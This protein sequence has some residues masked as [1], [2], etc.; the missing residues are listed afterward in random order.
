[1][2]IERL[3]LRNFKCYGETEFELS[4]GVT[5]I[6]GLNG[7]GKSSLLEACFF[8]LYGTKALETTL[9]EV[10]T[11]GEDEMT[12]ELWFTHSGESYHVHREVRVRDGSAH[13]AKCVLEGSDG[14]TE[15]A[16]DVRRRVTALLRM[17]VDAFINCAYVRQGE[18]NKLI[19]AKPSD[20]QD[21]LDEL[22]QLGKLEEYR[23]RASDARV[24]VGRVRDDKQ[25]ALGELD[26]QIAR[27]EEKGLH[28]RRSEVKSKLSRVTKETEK[29]E[30][31]RR[32]AEKTVEQA[33]S[34]LSEY[35]QKREQLDSLAENIETVR[36]RIQTTAR[37]REQLA[38]KIETATERVERAEDKRDKLLETLDISA[39]EPVSERVA[40]ALSE[41]REEITQ[42]TEQ[43]KEKSVEKQQHDSTHERV[44]ERA[45]ELESKAKEKRSEADRLESEVETRR[46]ELSEKRE[47]LD[48]LATEIADR[49]ELFAD[50]PVEIGAA[51]A[52]SEQ[53]SEELAE[54]R[55]RRAEKAAALE[56]ARKRLE[57][58]EQLREAGSCPECGQPV[59][60]S[61]HVDALGDRR[62]R[63]STL[64]AEVEQLRT[65]VSEQEATVSEAE[66][67]VEAE[68]EIEQRK[69]ERETL[70]QLLT[71]HEQTVEEKTERAA[72]LR[73]EATLDEEKATAAREEATDAETEAEHCRVQIAEANREKR[74]LTERR[75][76][77]ERLSETLGLLVEIRTERERLREQRTERTERNDERREQLQ[78]LRAQRD[79]LRE[80]VDEQRI[81]TAKRSRT[82]ATDYLEQVKPKLEEL[83]K[84]QRQLQETLGAIENE[85][86]ELEE[87]RERRKELAE[88]VE[89]LDSLYAEMEELEAM[90][91]TLRAQLRQ[92]NVETLE[93]ML[94]ETFELLYQNDTY[95]KLELDGEYQL[96]VYQKDG[97]KLDP[98]Q[99]SG[100]ERALFNL[101]LRCAI[102][103]LLAEGIE[104]TAPMPPLILDEPTVYLDA[105]HVT[106]LLELIESMYELG[107]DQ[108]LVVSHDETLVAAAD[109]LVRVRKDSTTNRSSVERGRDELLVEPH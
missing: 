91:A 39:S 106:Q 29:Y 62:K 13:T 79:E 40:S 52:Y 61:P 9:D 85:L 16:R 17:D 89:R 20:R 105:G 88:T 38:E 47:R 102:Y 76:T 2:K 27:K 4:S 32:E 10:V 54:L 68:R 41:V 8:A 101:S 93:R 14:I 18:V 64:E 1:M 36:T 107:V 82:E 63:V 50:A 81:E 43:I 84:S 97:E 87:L 15:G 74:Q 108:I 73:E 57:E 22:L 80:S 23:E 99:L 33:N 37:E 26:D 78:T 94:N 44:L 46:G 28:D 98:E 77:L 48:Q 65:T 49:R 95:A 59:E 96:R 90:Y 72:S 42:L 30:K 56:N 86:S 35:E 103:R 6:H 12:V 69:R 19:N 7:S 51:T 71:E 5:V 24:G 92:K 34:I 58:A 31:N 70:E 104:G 75:D 83:T 66:A 25:G 21:M 67:L 100:G 3:R 109:E 60:T 11:I 53:Q 45:K 55:E